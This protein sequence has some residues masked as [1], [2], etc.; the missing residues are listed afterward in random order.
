MAETL[1]LP[2][3]PVAPSISS[4]RVLVLYGPP[5]TGKTTLLSKLPNN[6]I[7]D[8]D[9]LGGT[10]FVSAIKVKAGSLAELRQVIGLLRQGHPYQF[11]TLDPL[12]DLEQMAVEFACELYQA[13]PMGKNWRYKKPEE[14]LD[15]PNGAGYR[16]LRSAF[17]EILNAFQGIAPRL[18]L[19]AHLRDK[20][21]TKKNGDEVAAVDLNLTG[22]LRNIVPAWA[23]ATAYMYR[24]GDKAFFSFK[25]RDEVN[26][27]ARNMPHL[28][29]QIIEISERLE[30][31]EVI[32]HWDRIYPD[33]LK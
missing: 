26:C 10:D 21:I 5:K 6:L 14:I 18:I 28:E 9:P 8:V 2:T 30:S 32:A 4:P 25:V 29:N 17:T 1:A 31:G 3:A 22:Q 20:M 23:D 33:L 13:S 12:T 7:V 16:W 27:G 24:E 11:V 19:S 15:L